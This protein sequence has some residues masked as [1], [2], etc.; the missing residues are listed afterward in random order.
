MVGGGEGELAADVC[1]LSIDVGFRL[2]EQRADA[3]ELISFEDELDDVT[4]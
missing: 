4:L 1:A 2:F 3:A